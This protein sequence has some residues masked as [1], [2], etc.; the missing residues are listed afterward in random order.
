[1]IHSL[2][3]DAFTSSPV[4]LYGAG[5]CSHWFLEIAMKRH[6][7]RPIAVLDRKFTR[8]DEW[9]DIPACALED[10]VGVREA[11]VVVS[12]GNPAA[13]AEIVTTLTTQGF[14]CVVP[15]SALYEIHN[16]FASSPPRFRDHQDAIVRAFDLMAD[17]ESREVY[18]CYLETHVQRRP[19]PIPMRP[20]D[21]QYFP[22][23]VP[24]SRG[25]DRTVC[26]GAY[27]GDTLRQ[28]HQHCGKVAA[29]ACFEPEPHIYARLVDYLWA[30]EGMIAGQALTWPCAVADHGGQVRFI[31]G[32]GLGSRI[33]DTGESWVQCVTLDQALPGFDPTF[34]SMDIEGTEPDALKGAERLIRQSRPDLGIC[35]YH[36][37]NHLWEIPLYL[38]DLNLGYRFY[39]RNY[40]GFAIE[41]VLYATT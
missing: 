15:L 31:R 37:P 8:G 26:C 2:S 13:C 6:G 1:M 4:I 21:E 18:L 33:S 9:H 14:R 7:I 11:T 10:Y 35:V 5:E 22:K 30:H 19:V 28:L 29:V 16:P 12:I 27:D 17:E 23:D 32:D 41:T 25:H 40:T 36:A 39:L 3:S 38:H 24:L 20:R 34:I